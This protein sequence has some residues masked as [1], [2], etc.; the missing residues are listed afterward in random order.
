MRVINSFHFAAMWPET[1]Y[2][3]EQGLAGLACTAFGLRLPP[4]GT[5]QAFFG[6]NP[7]SF[8][9]PRPGHTLIVF[10]MATSTLAKGDVQ[11]AARDGHAVPPG[12]G[13]VR[14]PASDDPAE[15]LKGVLLPFG[16]Y[17]GR[18]SR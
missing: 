16:G 10:D 4:A 8:A 14:W 7:I 17:K 2:L 11:I 9:L 18:L 15:I 12:T 1:E 5:S 13:L 3:A 6:T